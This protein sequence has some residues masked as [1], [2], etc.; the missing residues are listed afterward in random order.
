MG[1]ILASA[2]ISKASDQ[3]FDVTNVRWTVTELLGWLSQGQRAICA[4]KPNSNNKLASV[5]LVAG[6]KQAIPSDGWFLLGI[7]RNMGAG[8]VTPG[9]AVRITSREVMDGYNLN[10]HT[11]PASAVVDEYIFDLQD[12]TVFYVYPPNDG[13]GYVELNYAAVPADLPAQTSPITI[14]DVFEPILF[15]YVMFRGCAK[16]ASYAPGLQLAQMYLQ[17]F[18]AGVGAKDTAELQSNPDLQLAPFNP[19]VRG[20]AST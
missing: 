7:Y 6:T 15:D 2:I 1:T 13:T 16:D 20:A 9:Q 18:I 5:S 8:G 14:S 19:Q 10:W 11:D 12:Q 17:S 3:L 4:I